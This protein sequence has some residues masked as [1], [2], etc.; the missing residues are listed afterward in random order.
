M[1]SDL[2]WQELLAILEQLRIEIRW[3]RGEF[4]GGLYSTHGVQHFLLNEDHPRESQ[5]RVLCQELSRID[6][7]RL[8]LSPAVRDSIES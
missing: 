6:L 2:L 8:Y 5:I 7:S 4:K 3:S 1:H